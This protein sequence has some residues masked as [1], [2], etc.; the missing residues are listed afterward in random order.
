MPEYLI[1]LLGL[2]VVSFFLHKRFKV[3][4]FENN[5]QMIV[6]YFIMYGVGIIWDNFAIYRGHWSYPGVGLTGIYIGLAPLEDYIFLLVCT[7]FVLVLYKIMI[8]KY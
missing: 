5:K 7:Y 1:I 6:F 4:L 3:K 8:K 2:I